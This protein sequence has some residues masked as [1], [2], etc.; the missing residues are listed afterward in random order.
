M[1]K[2][3]QINDHLYVSKVSYGPRTPMTPLSL[4]FMQHTIPG[5]KIKSYIEQ[6]RYQAYL[7]KQGFD[8]EYTMPCFLT[9]LSSIFLKRAILFLY[10][11]LINSQ[12]IGYGDWF[13]SKTG[14]Q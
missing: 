13:Y 8:P 14:K 3:L 6:P 1:E 7:T 4:P 2:S 5:T 10:A 11:G 12:T 9:L